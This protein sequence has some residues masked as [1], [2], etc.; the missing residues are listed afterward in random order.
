MQSAS[1]DGELKMGSKKSYGR[2]PSRRD[3]QQANSSIGIWKKA[4]KD[5][6]E[7]LCPVRAGGHECGCLPM[8]ARLVSVDVSFLFCCKSDCLGSM[9]LHLPRFTKSEKY[10][11]VALS[12]RIS[13]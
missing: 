10:N 13:P 3:C 4:F 11:S 2:T 8:L 7:R 12:L 5:A 6:S 1:E 9:A